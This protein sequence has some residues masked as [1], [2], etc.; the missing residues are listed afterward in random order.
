MVRLRTIYRR[1][2]NEVAQGGSLEAGIHGYG[3]NIRVVVGDG[4]P[5]ARR[6]LR[7][8]L[9]TDN[10]TVVAEAVNGREVA[11]LVAFY[12]PDLVLWDEALEGPNGPEPI[13]TIHSRFPDIAIVVLAASPD[14]A[15][16]LRILRAGASGYLHK[17]IDPGT[18]V[19][20]LRGV[21]DGE[22]GV[23]RRLAMRVIESDRRGLRGGVGLRPVRS[24][25]TDREWE[26][27][28]LVSS[29]ART[30]DIARILVLSPETVRSHLKNLYRKLGVSSREDAAAAAIRMRDLVG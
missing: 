22:A 8:T 18:L 24:E 15:R 30:D 3:E 1:R 9:R 23:S 6:L 26:V 17:E 12:K 19:R 11:E 7:D 10:V 16:G 28:D 2:G 20:V 29:G 5:L 14:D 4:D 21:L 27:L 13:A 25:L